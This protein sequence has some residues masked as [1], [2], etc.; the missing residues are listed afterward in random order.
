MELFH[1]FQEAFTQKKFKIKKNWLC[2][3]ELKTVVSFFY[4]MTKENLGCFRKT[5]GY[6][7]LKCS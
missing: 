7:I 5:V 2:N 1:H 3:C 4:D 6:A